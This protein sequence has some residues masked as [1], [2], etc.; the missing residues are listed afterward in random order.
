MQNSHRFTI[1][2]GMFHKAPILLLAVNGCLMSRNYITFFSTILAI[3]SACV[4]YISAD[5]KCYKIN[6]T[7]IHYI[8][9]SVLFSFHSQSMTFLRDVS[10]AKVLQFEDLFTLLC[11]PISQKKT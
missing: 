2:I 4:N 11:Y 9:F 5:I 3:A 10:S 6:V 7:K 1:I 8:T